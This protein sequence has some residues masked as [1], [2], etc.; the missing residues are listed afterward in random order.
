MTEDIVD[1][2]R[3]LFGAF[4]RALK[5][6]GFA[7]LQHTGDVTLT[8]SSSVAASFNVNRSL[9]GLGTLK[10]PVRVS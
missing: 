6:L 5:L 1:R 7:E 8:A 4:R 10:G 2:F 3:A 9:R